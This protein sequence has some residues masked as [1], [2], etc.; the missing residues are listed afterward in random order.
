MAWVSKS[1]LMGNLLTG[2]EVQARGLR[3][4][5]VTS[6]QLGAQTLYRLRALNS[7]LRDSGLVEL[8]LLHPF[9]P[10]EPIIHEFQPDKAAPLR[11][12]L[13]YHHAFLLEQAL[14]S[15]ALLSVQPGRLRMEPYQLVPVLRA[16][17]MGRVRLLL[18]DGVGLGK[19][20]QAGLVLTELMARRVAHRLLIVSPA[21]PLLDQW[22]EEMSER[23]GLRLDEVNRARLEE[24]RRSKELG[25]NPFDHVPLGIASIDFL[26][27]ERILDLVER[28]S[29]DV[30]VIDESHHCMD[31]GTSEREDSQRRRLAEVL[32]RR[33]DSL[34][35]LTATPHDGNDRSFSSLCELLDPSLVDGK[36]V[37]RGD[38]Y[39]NHVVRRLKHHI[40]DPVTK[41]EKFKKRIVEPCPVEASEAKHPNFIALQ[42]GLLELLAPQL[43]RAFKKRQYSDVLAYLAL[44]KRSVSTVAACCSTLEVVSERYQKILTEGSETQDS[45]KQRLRSLRDYYRKLE[46][47]GTVTAEEEQE[48]ARLEAEELA[49][50][51]VEMQQEIRAGQ[52]AIRW[53]RGRLSR[54]PG[55]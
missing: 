27:Q 48:Q 46:R 38:R 39:R 51:L 30:V 28:A 8:D 25:A 12:W 42:R 32:A 9:E 5:V 13:V 17:G 37:L 18:A 53:G 35:L 45:K 41:E 49:Q 20:I 44:L 43:R 36:G 47:F 50:K 1:G 15:Q 52:N 55:L 54:M 11:N 3:W 2:T 7:G 19:T 23:F 10:I 31:L 14:G 40:I 34:L 4:E 22:K 29:Y 24:I 26:K 33:C 16:I 6:T 21:G